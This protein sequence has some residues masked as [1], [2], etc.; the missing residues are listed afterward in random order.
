M[1]RREDY[2]MLS[3][4]EY[5][6]IIRQRLRAELAAL[7]QSEIEAELIEATIAELRRRGQT[8]EAAQREQQVRERRALIAAIRA[9]IQASLRSLEGKDLPKG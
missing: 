3:D 2:S 5:V 8:E 4:D 1:P 7:L 9:K 6:T